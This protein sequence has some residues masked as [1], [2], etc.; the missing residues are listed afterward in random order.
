[1]NLDKGKY[2]KEELLSDSDLV[3]VVMSLQ[4]ELLRQQDLLADAYLKHEEVQRQNYKLLFDAD[5]EAARIKDETMK[6]YELVQ[7]E[8]S[9]F[10]HNYHK[11][12]KEVRSK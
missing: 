7:Q 1:M 2:F 4:D 12:L 3:K 11:Q 9:G 5:L 6:E 10:V 8:Y